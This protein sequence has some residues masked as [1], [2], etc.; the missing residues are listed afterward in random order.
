MSKGKEN[1]MQKV[2][3]WAFIIGIVIAIIAGLVY[4]TDAKGLSGAIVSILVVLGLI[5]G[6]LNV[7]GKETMSFLAAAVSLIIVTYFG[8]NTLGSIAVVGAYL[9]SIFGAMMAFVMGA[10]VIVCLKAIWALAADE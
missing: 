6:F 5:V 3:S 9:S 8:G 7:T 1:T 2:G 10:T 4:A